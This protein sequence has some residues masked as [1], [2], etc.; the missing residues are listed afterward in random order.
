MRRYVFAFPILALSACSFLESHQVNPSGVHAQNV[1]YQQ[2]YSYR[3][4]TEACVASPCAPRFGFPFAGQHNMPSFPPNGLP[5]NPSSTHGLRGPSYISHTACCSKTHPYQNARPHQLRGMHRSPSYDTIGNSWFGPKSPYVYPQASQLR[6]MQHQKS[7]S[8]YGTLG[9]V[10]YDDDFEIF[11]VEGR[12]GYDT[13][14]ILGVELEGSIGVI[15]ENK[16][17]NDPSIGDVNLDIG[18]NYNI[19]A[20]AVARIPLSTE[21][22]V[23]GRAGYDFRQLHVNGTA[24][25]GTSEAVSGDLNGFALGA[26][27]EYSL[28]QRSGLRFDVTRYHN[29]VESIES[30]S[31]SFTRKF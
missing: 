27:A 26:G 9:G 31:A 15:D 23:H 30:I 6:G 21:L 8:F 12:L 24:E 20:F 22:S 14:H 25:D 19:A 5:Q 2:G 29:D 3:N 18:S 7:G 11:G 28:S 17:V 13:G 4:N 1:P 10:L 16:V